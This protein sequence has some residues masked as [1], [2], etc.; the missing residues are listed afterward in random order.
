MD[1]V[2]WPP[3]P[4]GNIVLYHCVNSSF[5]LLSR[6]GNGVMVAYHLGSS[7]SVLH[8]FLGTSPV[9]ERIC[10]GISLRRDGTLGN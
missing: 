2:Q 9:L 1:H 5:I 8:A 10:K 6:H 4:S 3:T 7:L